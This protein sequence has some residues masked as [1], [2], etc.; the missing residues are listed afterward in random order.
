MSKMNSWE[1]RIVDAFMAKYP[2]AVAT[3]SNKVLR[4]KANKLFPDFESA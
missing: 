1:K 2:G 3:G 4:L